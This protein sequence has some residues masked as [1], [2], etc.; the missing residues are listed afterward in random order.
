MVRFG[1]MTRLWSI[2]HLCIH[3]RNIFM[4][5]I[6]TGIWVGRDR[7][8]NGEVKDLSML[9]LATYNG[10]EHV[11][12]CSV[13]TMLRLRCRRDDV[14]LQCDLSSIHNMVYGIYMHM[15]T[16]KCSPNARMMVNIMQNINKNDQ[17]PMG[18]CDC[19]IFHPVA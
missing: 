11:F 5:E 4:N 18:N 16:E 3:I 19:A 12:G 7:N 6:Q 8:A 2:F 1:S 13:C 17:W 14:R 10:R 9:L 15:L